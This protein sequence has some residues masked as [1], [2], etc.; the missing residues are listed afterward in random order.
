MESGLSCNFFGITD[1]VLMDKSKI[2]V[3]NGIAG[4]AKS[5]N[6]HKIFQKKGIDYARFTSTNKLK[7]DAERRYGGYVETIAG[8]MF[9]T[10]NGIFYDTE[11]DVGYSN[12]VIDEVLQSNIKVFDWIM[13]RVGKVNII[14]CTDS[15]QLM[16]PENEEEMRVAF[17]KFVKNECVV[18]ILMKK[19]YRPRDEDT[20]K[21]Y[22]AAWRGVE[23]KENAFRLFIKKESQFRGT[24]YDVR[25]MKFDEMNYDM[26][27][28]YLC[29]SNDI[30]EMV[31]NKF[32]LYHYYHANLVPKGKIA[33]RVPRKKE[34]YPI[35][36]Q[37]KVKRN[38]NGY[39]QIENVC[40]THRYQG[41]EVTS[42]QKL[43]YILHR[44]SMVSNREFYTM[45][46]RM[47]NISSLVLVACEREEDEDLVTYNRL[48]IKKLEWFEMDE[49]AKVGDIEIGE[50]A[51]DSDSGI[52]KIPP[53][54]FR[55]LMTKVRDNENVHY[56][57]S[58]FR[59]CGKIF[60]PEMGEDENENTMIHAMLASEPA[61]EYKWMKKFFIA[62]EKSQMNYFKKGD[63]PI[64]EPKA[65]FLCIQESMGNNPFDD[66]LKYVSVRKKE[67]FGY[68]IDLKASFPHI[69]AMCKIATGNNFSRNKVE[70]ESIE[71]WIVINSSA[72]SDG[73]IVSGEVKEIIKKYE[74]GTFIRI[75]E[76]TAMTGCEYGK[77]L[78]EMS[79]K[80]IE[81]KE[82]LKG[83]KYGYASKRWLN[84]IYEK[85]H[86]DVCAFYIEE[87]NNHSPMMWSVVSAQT[88]IMLNIKLEIYGK[89]NKGR[90]IAD[91]LYFDYN[92]DIIELGKRIKKRIKG[93]DFRIFKNGEDDKEGEI[94]YQTYK[95]LVSKKEAKAEKE[96]VRRMQKKIDKKA[97][98]W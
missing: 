73:A 4:S 64:W 6:I 10:N 20:A 77:K 74:G 76:S 48:P 42:C 31:Y 13:N 9:N 11:K 82:K 54:E 28:V 83:I 56:R 61:M 23:G 26:G 65:P 45:I 89:I 85:V 53:E 18:N 17:E 49:K 16:S 93:H 2:K 52:I 70:G 67:S 87:K 97:K 14:V 33:K 21:C 95:N 81:D 43:Y 46:T 15:S 51:R 79:H 57:E 55:A 59:C 50:M 7:R 27:D 1:D 29:H 62:L 38:M 91:C 47:Y 96:R 3:I 25:Y 5:S 30:E 75:G 98:I 19:T 71:W 69:L 8:G 12:V 94:L 60:F 68:G 92:G 72:V 41:S 39:F 34:G 35:I 86:G 44:D 80:S 22:Y 37:N 40:T 63:A 36:P 78:H 58:G 88:E 32:D 66:V 84:P 90:V 24:S